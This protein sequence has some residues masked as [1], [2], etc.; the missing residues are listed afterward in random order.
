M[1]FIKHIKCTLYENIKKRIKILDILTLSHDI[2]RQSHHIFFFNFD[3]L[4][5][6][7]YWGRDKERGFVASIGQVPLP[8]TIMPICHHQI[9]IFEGARLLNYYMIVWWCCSDAQM[10]ILWCDIWLH[11]F[12]N[13]TIE[14]LR[15]N[16]PIL[17]L[18]NLKMEVLG[19]KFGSQNWKYYYLY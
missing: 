14:F 13:H 18:A 12:E 10:Y 7:Q 9:W 4:C 11:I 5:L 1:F 19:A 6:H 15:I 8:K 16:I 17:F 2:L 3:Q